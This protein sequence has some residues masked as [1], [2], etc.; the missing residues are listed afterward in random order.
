MKTKI[1]VILLMMFVIS[2]NVYAETDTIYASFNEIKLYL[3]NTRV[4]KDTMLY[5]GTTYVPLRAIS[6]MLNLEINY[7]DETKSVYLSETDK[8]VEITNQYARPD[9]IYG[10]IVLNTYVDNNILKLSY[11]NNTRYTIEEYK[12]IWLDTRDDAS[13]MF[14]CGKTTPGQ[15]S[16]VAVGYDL[17]YEVTADGSYYDYLDNEIFATYNKYIDDNGRTAVRLCNDYYDISYYKTIDASFNEISLY[18]NNIKVDKE[19]LLY[20]GTT[21]VPLR[22]IS[23]ILGLEVEYDYETKS[24]YLTTKSVLSNTGNNKKAIETEIKPNESESRNKTFED[25]FVWGIYTVKTNLSDK[26]LKL[27]ED[28][29]EKS[30]KFRIS[31]IEIFTDTVVTRDGAIITNP[32]VIISAREGGIVTGSN[33]RR[34][35]LAMYFKNN[36]KDLV[37]HEFIYHGIDSRT[38]KKI[39]SSRYSPFPYGIVYGASSHDEEEG[40]GGIPVLF[41]ETSENGNGVSNSADIG[42]EFIY[43]A[44][45]EYIK[46]V[47]IELI[48]NSVEFYD[49]SP[50]RADFKLVYYFESDSYDITIEINGNGQA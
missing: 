6:E 32:G 42:E 7:I 23:E 34:D 1:V 8:P 16:N 48:I 46:P 49:N 24:V 25:S 35:V 18:L 22:A 11:T 21:Y 12:I 3:D 50:L 15:T 10:E 39:T 33:V 17:D 26:N 41:I 5:N 9:I 20:N 38:G 36:S 19:T 27:I 47:Y 13:I 28:A 45:E 4:E 40:Y 2:M 30:K 44:D 37:I 29:Y 43:V 14:I 31:D